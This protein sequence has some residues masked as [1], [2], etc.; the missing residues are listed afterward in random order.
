MTGPYARGERP[1]PESDTL[2]I[3]FVQPGQTV[4]LQFPSGW[5][6]LLVL[7]DDEPPPPL[8]FPDEWPDPNARW[9]W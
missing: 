6:C 1:L 5:G 7:V 8:P 9:S 3:L 4:V 2:P